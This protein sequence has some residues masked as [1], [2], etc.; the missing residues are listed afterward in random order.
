MF[1]KTY[2]LTPKIHNKK[3][4]L[5]FKWKLACDHGKWKAGKGKNAL[6]YQVVSSAVIKKLLCSVELL[7]RQ[8]P[9]SHSYTKPTLSLQGYWDDVPDSWQELGVPRSI[10]LGKKKTKQ[11]PPQKTSE[12]KYY[13]RPLTGKI[14]VRVL[15]SSKV[16]CKKCPVCRI[17]FRTLK[18]APKNSRTKQISKWPLRR[19][20]GAGYWWFGDLN[21]WLRRQLPT[22][23]YRHRGCPSVVKPSDLLPC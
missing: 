14:K 7:C 8:N 3:F 5:L 2:T 9:N 16:K 23:I 1:R 22:L 17:D 18:M 12:E 21:S 13:F 15:P 11:K 19:F 20:V 6:K 10:S 4:S